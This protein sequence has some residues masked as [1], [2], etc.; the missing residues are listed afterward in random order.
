MTVV[1]LV[2]SA[3]GI[4]GLSQDQDVGVASERIGKDGDGLQVD[5]G[6]VTRSLA[7]G[8]TVKVPDGQVIDLDAIRGN[9]RDGLYQGNMLANAKSELSSMCV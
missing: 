4:P 8:G 5:I 7:G 2:R 3:I 1:V 9:F 6:V